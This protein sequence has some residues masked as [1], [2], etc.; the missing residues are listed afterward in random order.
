MGVYFR[1]FFSKRGGD[2]AEKLDIELIIAGLQL[3]RVREKFL[4]GFEFFLN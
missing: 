3:L 4:R 2:L 1:L